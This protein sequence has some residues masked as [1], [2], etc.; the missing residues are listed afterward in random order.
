MRTSIVM[1]GC[2]LAT[3]AARAGSAEL[4][5]GFARTGPFDEQV[6]W[7]RHDGGVR[8]VVNA[9]VAL[10]ADR[11]RLLVIYATP[12]GN[13]LEQTLGCAAAE[14]RDWRF[15][16]QH[17][18]A[19]TR[20]LRQIE[21]AR[22]VILAVTQAPKTSWPLFR[23]EEP[24][25]D[26]IIREL[27]ESLTRE[28][29]A[30]R[31]ALA[32]HSGGGSFV[33]GYVGAVDAIPDSIERIVLLD[34]NY[35]YS[36]AEHGEKLLEW[37]A[38]APDARLVV[39]AYDDR[40]ITVEGKKII[41]PD[42]GTFRATE[43]MLAR[44]RKDVELTEGKHGA[45][46][47]VQS[48][49][50]RIQF[51]V[52]PNPENKI[53]H[54]ALVGQ[55]NG[56][57]HGLTVGTR[58]EETWGPFGGPRVYGKW[59]APEPPSEP[60]AT[61]EDAPGH[62]GIRLK[63]PARPA[64]APSGSQ[65]AER[66]AVLALAQREAAVVRE[67]TR[68]NVPGFLRRLKPIHTTCTDASGR[69]H[70]GTYYVT[71]D[72][73]A[74]GSDDDFFRVP[75]TPQT[76]LALADALGGAMMTTKTSDDVHAAAEVRLAPCPL[77]E[78]RESV[79]TFLEHH[80]IIE[81]QRKGKPRGQL[82]SGI[83]KDV[84]LSNRLAERPHRVAIY[85]WHET[86]GRPIQ[87]LYVGHADRY[88]D[89][90]HGLRLLAGEMVVDGSPMRVADVLADANLCG[91]LSREGPIDVPAIRQAAGWGDHAGQDPRQAAFERVFGD[92]ARLAP[93]TVARVRKSRPGQRTTVALGRAD[94]PEEVWFLDPDARHTVHPILVRVIDEDGDLARDGGPDLDSDLYVADYG[95]NGTVDS[96]VDYQ[97]NDGDGDADEMAI[98]FWHGTPQKGELRVWGYRDDGDD[99]LMLYDVNWNYDQRLCQF[100]CHLGGDATLVSLHL[101]SDS[102]RWISFF[103]NPFV[104]YDPD[105]DGTSEITVRLT[106]TNNELESLRYSLDA[107]GDAHGPWVHDYDFSISAWAEGVNLRAKTPGGGS[108]VRFDSSL[109][110]TTTLR[111]IPT[112]EILKREAA[113]RVAETTPWAV[114][115]LAWDEMNANTEENVGRA[116]NRR[117]EG[118]IGK[119][120]PHFRQV[121]GPPTG[122]LNRRYEIV[123][124]A[125]PL[126]LY[127]DA[128]DRRLHLLGAGPAEGHLEVDYDLDGR[129]DARYTYLDRD[130]DGVFDRRVIDLDGDDQ[131]EFN[132]PMQGDSARRFA[133]D[134]DPLVAFY[135]QTLDETL[136][137][138][139]RLIDAARA[140]LGTEGGDSESVAADP[141]ETFFL[142]KL[143]SW[144]PEE[145]LGHRMRSTPEGAR[146]YVDL[147]R[148]RMLW[149]LKRR[150]GDRS[151]WAAVESA[152]A[153]GRYAEAARVVLSR[154]APGAHPAPPERFGAFERRVPIVI[155]NTGGLWRDDFPVVLRVADLQA[156]ARDFNPECCAVV[157]AERWLDWREVPH[158]LDRLDEKTGRELSFLARVPPGERAIWYVYYSP[159]GKRDAT[160]PK[161][162][163]TDTGWDPEG[164]NV[165]WESVESAYRAYDGHFDFFGK[166]TYD[167][168]RK[169]E[170]FIYPIKSNKNA[171]YHNEMPWGI[172]AL[173][174]GDTPGLGGLALVLGERT[175]PVYRRGE[176]GTV[177]F[178]R[179]VL[180]AGPVR[181]AVELVARN[182]VPERPE[183]RV[184]IVCLLYA[185]HAESEVR[186]QLEGGP[187]ET[188]L[189]PG[190]TRLR[191]EETFVERSL[192]CLGAWGW[193]DDKIGEVGLGLIVPPEAL[194]DV[195]EE[196]DHRQMRCAG[197]DGSL[198]YWIVGQWRRGRRFPV[199]PTITN[200]RGELES[201]AG[202]LHDPARVAVGPPEDV[203]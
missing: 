77:V 115:C 5:P 143:E 23:R 177:A 195:L 194:K 97:D 71:P 135:R 134:Y 12:N 162:T 19:Q 138:S 155:D 170:W 101:P 123:R 117:W 171:N 63:L 60:A 183:L 161:R 106:G 159:T 80:R 144:Y 20:C 181:A 201:L 141:A 96:G 190:L 103:E 109:G 9:P 142:T 6:R 24:R 113:Q 111:G 163:G 82:V 198:R 93:D 169:V 174:V 182:V 65:F 29:R 61:R 179:R 150:F 43:R 64:D 35:S 21:S 66:I 22:D 81:R 56:L 199:A 122:R 149:R 192:G 196:P 14:D 58:Q 133:L 86:D 57:V 94:R 100:R 187:P 107:D 40:E 185:H 8:V 15:D 108:K 1:T 151:A 95:A 152:S 175:W 124:P 87:P 30:E 83:K 33:L 70:E 186:A 18:A 26:R 128:T 154:L 31:V 102:D 176:K 158:Q 129:L 78:D 98:Y 118:V 47:R 92:A 38:R 157:A 120:L 69:R 16:L 50:G 27:V 28:F 104:F 193:Q 130:G 51:F 153:A 39:I 203:R 72:Y 167:H 11:G 184:R 91:L 13:T 188:I 7:S 2:L 44:F 202:Q 189:A 42:G 59:I 165:G 119:G 62:S 25:A 148:D 156:V 67:V 139:Q 112:T 49:D 53:L 147:V 54:T 75:V 178:D 45:F 68:G 146:A 160:F 166:H 48:A 10:R 41:G 110:F 125:V 164:L 74:V 76:A 90:S 116:P 37:L 145:Q 137:E 173:H 73:L 121:G 191:C 89:Y 34:A 4:L 88:V 3:I 168:S 79:A 32:C 140:A 36:D 84:V 55:M 172:D 114:A 99:N 131:A 85:G 180:A 105:G 52:H 46:R 132:W 17:V 200:W 127:Y 197:D 126:Q 136:E